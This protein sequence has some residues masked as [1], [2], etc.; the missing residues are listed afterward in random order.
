M[1]KSYQSD[2]KKNGSVVLSLGAV[3]VLAISALVISGNFEKIITPF[4]PI[5]KPKASSNQPT[6]TQMFSDV[7][8]AD[9]INAEKWGTWKN[10][11]ASI[12]QTAANNLRMDIPQGSV[13]DKA[14]QASLV[15]KVALE[16]KKDFR[17]AS[18]LYPPTVTGEGTGVSGFRFSSTGTGDDEGAVLKWTVATV[19]TTTTRKVQFVVRGPDGKVMFQ[20]EA[21]FASP[22]GM[23]RLDRVSDTYRAFY[24]AGRDIT[25]D[26]AWTA[27]GEFKHETLGNGGKLTLFTANQAKA[28]PKVAG[29]FD[30]VRIRWQGEESGNMEFADAFSAGAISAKWQ[31]WNTTGATVKETKYDNLLIGIPTGAV[32]NKPGS[33]RFVRKE[34]VV[35]EGKDFIMTT[36]LYKPTVTGDGTGASGLVFR[37]FTEVDKEVAMIRWEVTNTPTS[38]LVFLVKNPDGTLS[39]KAS[40]DVTAN[41]LTLRLSRKGDKYTAHYRVGDSDKDL[42]KIGKDESVEF[43]AD[44]SLGLF[45]SNVGNDTKFPK[46]AAR[47][48]STWGRLA[49]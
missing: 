37:S 35:G 16:D 17:I 8:K 7:F 22:V 25:S 10:G 19:G 47:F 49:K 28:Y 43:G 44:G 32:D 46:V 1:A 30:E 23:L 26:T 15:Y 27:L 11:D 6:L 33:V 40:V 13:E 18:T 38:K 29:R 41:K 2:T 21:D 31:T 14:K 12:K 3:M 24:K 20:K 34:P 45:A 5:I 39:Q 48:D 36:T 4:A 42:V 9:A